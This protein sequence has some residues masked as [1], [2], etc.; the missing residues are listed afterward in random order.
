MKK[1]F[2]LT[3]ILFAAFLCSCS[4]YSQGGFEFD[5]GETLSSEELESLFG[6]TEPEETTFVLNENTSVYWTEG[7]SKYH[8]FSDCGHLSKSA[9]I[10][11]GNMAKAA[12]KGKTECCKTCESRAGLSE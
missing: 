5:P 4:P 1:T 10:K 6:E 3:L 8:L 11:T 12:E 9:E 7:G 2:V